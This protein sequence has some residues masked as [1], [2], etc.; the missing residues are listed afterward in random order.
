MNKGDFVGAALVQPLGSD[1]IMTLGGTADDW[2]CTWVENGQT[3]TGHF[4]P[5]ELQL[6]SGARQK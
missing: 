4:Q 5:E 3:M 6:V 2:I 1:Q